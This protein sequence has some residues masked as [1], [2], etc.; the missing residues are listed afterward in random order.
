VA[1][2]CHSGQQDTCLNRLRNRNCEAEWI[3]ST[4]ISIHF[5]VSL[6]KDYVAK[7]ENKKN[8][9][10]TNIERAMA[11]GRGRPSAL[12]VALQARIP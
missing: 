2:S 10:P 4:K 9:I 7:K 1:G 6:K 12:A 11:H 8:G 5:N 3:P